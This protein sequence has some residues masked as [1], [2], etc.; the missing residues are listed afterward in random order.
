MERSMVSSRLQKGDLILSATDIGN[1]LRR[2]AWEIRER[3]PQVLPAFVGIET[4]GVTVARRVRKILADDGMETSLGTI[5]ISLYRDDLD[6]RQSV[7]ALRPTDLP[8]EV[9]DA[10]IILFDDVLFTGR[11]INAAIDVLTDYGRPASVELAVLIDRGNR[12]LPIEA[13]Y[14][15]ESI[16]TKPDDYI[17]VAFSEHDEEDGITFL[18]RDKQ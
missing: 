14:I 11:T 5:D 12:E 16:G 4:R 1:K 10:E 18:G 2:L 17:H 15:G 13:N 8:F 9:E 7:P 3:H 6:R